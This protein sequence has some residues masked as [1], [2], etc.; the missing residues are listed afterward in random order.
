M[1]R[2]LSANCFLAILASWSACRRKGR[3]S[4]LNLTLSVF[5][6][7]VRAGETSR[8]LLTSNCTLR[9]F[10]LVWNM[11]SPWSHSVIPRFSFCHSA[12]NGFFADSLVSM[13][14]LVMMSLQQFQTAPASH[15]V[16][17]CC[18]IVGLVAL[19]P[20][21]IRFTVLITVLCSSLVVLPGPTSSPAGLQFLTVTINAPHGPLCDPS[22]EFSDHSF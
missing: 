14:M 13:S 22:F 5:I 9:S 17:T 1:A 2:H 4:W 6:W 8:R 7:Q 20:R 12:R 19:F 11:D 10:A 3:P 16:M 18:S 21:G 15:V